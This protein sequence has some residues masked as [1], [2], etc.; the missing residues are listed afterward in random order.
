M[1]DNTAVVL[2][3]LMEILRKHNEK[4]TATKVLTL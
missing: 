1:T 4:D 3:S 2:V